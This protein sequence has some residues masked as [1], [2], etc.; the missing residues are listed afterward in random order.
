MYQ[1][2]GYHI[3][4][5]GVQNCTVIFSTTAETPVSGY[6]RQQKAMSF[7]FPGGSEEVFT[8][9]IQKSSNTWAMRDFFSCY[10]VK[11]NGGY[12]QYRILHCVDCERVTIISKKINTP[13]GISL[14]QHR[15]KKLRS[16]S[17]TFTK[18]LKHYDYQRIVLPRLMYWCL[19]SFVSETYWRWFSA[20]KL[21]GVI[22]NLYTVC[23]PI[24]RIRLVNVNNC[25]DNERNG[26]NIR[27]S[28]NIFKEN[29]YYYYFNSVFNWLDSS[30]TKN[31]KIKV[32]FQVKER[33]MSFSRP[34]GVICWTAK[35]RQAGVCCC[36][37]WRSRRR[38]CVSYNRSA[39]TSITLWYFELFI[40]H[41]AESMKRKEERKDTGKTIAEKLDVIT[42][43]V[44]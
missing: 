3:S 22:W 8:C 11:V 26:I 7:E 1:K 9:D 16:H 18:K 10:Y 27:F 36:Q 24:V 29:I 41:N 39:A 42:E 13:W 21:V 31:F 25:K 44:N 35:P 32:V 30:T 40:P 6:N 4:G 34:D 20:P 12:N 43:V 28:D 38:H 19:Y 5:I 14:Y 33:W 17:I 2:L 23:N 15:C 37:P